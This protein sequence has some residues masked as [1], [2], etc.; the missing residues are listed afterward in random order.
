MRRL[1]GA[2]AAGIEVGDVVM[3]VDGMDMW[4]KSL[5]AVTERIAAGGDMVVFRVMRLVHFPE[6][7]ARGAVDALQLTTAA[8]GTVDVAMV[9]SSAFSPVPS[10]AQQQ[11]PKS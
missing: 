2:A 5:K 10:Q 3:A 1:G 4:G 9:R 7:P 8:A 6:R 11:Q